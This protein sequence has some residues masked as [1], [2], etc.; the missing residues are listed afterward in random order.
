MIGSHTYL[1]RHLRPDGQVCGGQGCRIA[2]IPG[3]HVR[4]CHCGA[5]FI[6]VVTVAAISARMSRE[7]LRCDWKDSQREPVAAA[8]DLHLVG[9]GTSDGADRPPSRPTHPQGTP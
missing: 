1:P 2:G 3:E 5:T 4:R 6:A 7:I 9:S 8:D